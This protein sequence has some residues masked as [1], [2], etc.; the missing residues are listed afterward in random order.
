VTQLAL[1]PASVHAVAVNEDGAVIPTPPD[2]VN[3]AVIAPTFETDG[4]T[5]NPVGVFTSLVAAW[6]RRSRGCKRDL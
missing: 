5:E 2:S 6:L 3:E 1:I 4:A